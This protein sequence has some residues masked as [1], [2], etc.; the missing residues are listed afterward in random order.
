V[1]IECLA[2]S[3][4]PQSTQKS[5]DIGQVTES[6]RTRRKEGLIDCGTKTMFGPR[7]T[8]RSCS[9][10]GMGRSKPTRAQ[11]GKEEATVDLYRLRRPTLDSATRIAIQLGIF[12]Q[13]KEAGSSGLGSATDHLARL[14]EHIPPC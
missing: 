2:R 5:R 3:R 14:L 9:E 4:K 10:D 7:D 11:G 12:E 13:L 6:G 8:N 1:P